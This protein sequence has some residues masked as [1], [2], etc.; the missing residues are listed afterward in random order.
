[1]KKHIIII[2]A[3]IIGL[4]IMRPTTVHAQ[5]DC[6]GCVEDQCKRAEEIIKENHRK[7]E[8]DQG[9]IM[10]KV[11]EG[12]RNHRQWLHQ[13]FFKKQILP[14]MAQF[15]RQMTAIAMH[16]VFGIGQLFDAELQLQTQ[17]EIQT[18][19]IKAHDDYH[20]S[21]SLC[22]LGTSA[23]SLANT[24]QKIELNQ[25]ALSVTQLNRALGKNRS[26]GF[27]NPDHD[28]VTRWEVF[29]NNHCDP[30][31][32]GWLQDK[33]DKTGLQ[34]I[35]ESKPKRAN[36]DIDFTRIISEPRTLN[37]DFTDSA[38]TDTETDIIA[39]SQNLYGHDLTNGQLPGAGLNNFANQDLYLKL[40]SL[41]AKRQV[42]EHSFNAIVALKSS[43]SD[44]MFAETEE[45]AKDLPNTS[46]YLYELLNELG[47]SN[48]PGS[49]V[50]PGEESQA[51]ELLGRNPSYYAQL[52]VLSKKIYQNPDF[53]VNLYDKPANIKR[54]SAALLAIERMLDQALLESQH[55]QEMAMS[56]LLSAN[57]DRTEW[58]KIQREISS[59]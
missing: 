35:C 26:T 16:Q 38:K 17:R 51:E 49:G 52:E 48:A 11:S 42:A 28:L 50:S 45:A 32:N 41:S 40:R 36:A 20:P 24:D 6:V 31:N 54:K 33:A 44:K 29:E 59:K 55:R 4:T 53:Y 21:E 14:A 19:K 1:M 43:G 58:K 2:S 47:V 8:E 56:V 30:K 34:P 15:S 10:D 13:E 12:F 57:I 7:Y 5:N 18:L 27:A 9:E 25:T 3:F 23:R 46:K 22:V 37:V 39:L